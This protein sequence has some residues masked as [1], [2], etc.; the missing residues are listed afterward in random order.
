MNIMKFFAG[1]LP[2]FERSRITED[3]EQLISDLKTALIPAYKKAA[4]LTNGQ[5]FKSK[6][7][8]AFNEAFIR[9]FDT[10]RRRG[11]IEGILAILLTMPDKLSA[12]EKQVVELFAKDVTKD[13]MTYRKASLLRLLEIHRFVVDYSGRLLQRVVAAESYQKLGIED[14]IDGQLSAAELKW[15][16]DNEEAFFRSLQLLSHSSSDLMRQVDS[17]PDITIVSESAEIVKHSVGVDK[18]DP[19]RLN[20]IAARWNPIYHLRLIHS[21]WQVNAH[22][23]RLEEKRNLEFRLLQ[24]KHAS[25]GRRD[26]KLEQAIEYNEGRLTQLRFKIAEQEKEFA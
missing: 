5:G 19:M 23:E 13:S 2:S 17:I 6:P 12:I 21:E 16:K 11:F 1:L 20:F 10:Y 8:I 26:P 24:L 3:A 14:Q 18:L 4:E 9:Q 15:L 7:V 25:E 22:K